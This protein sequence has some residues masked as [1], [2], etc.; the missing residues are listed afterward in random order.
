[1]FNKRGQGLSTQAIILIVLGV[2]VLAILILGFTM[3]WKNIAPWLGGG[4]NVKT[5]VDACSVACGTQSQYDYCT[6]ERELKDANDNE[7][8]TTCDVLS[9]SYTTY[10]IAECPSVTC[11]V[12]KIHDDEGKAKLACIK[13]S[14]TLNYKDGTL[15]K[16][17]K[18]E[19]DDLAKS[20][21][22]AKIRCLNL[23]SGQEIQY[24]DDDNLQSYTCVPEDITE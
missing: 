21:D 18:C 4:D 14:A 7:I 5:I 24:V 20:S 8:K 23:K 10:G 16:I 1:M 22:D 3:G 6:V 11:G 19:K 13:D 2:F 12:G 9:T 17:Y 15:V